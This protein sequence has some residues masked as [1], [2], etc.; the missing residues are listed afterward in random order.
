M[1]W[2]LVYQIAG[3]MG[4]YIGGLARIVVN[5]SQMTIDLVVAVIQS[6]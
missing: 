3:E 2:S 1:N 5:V 4:S 6:R